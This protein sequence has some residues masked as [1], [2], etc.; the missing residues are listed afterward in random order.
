MVDSV[1]VDLDAKTRIAVNRVREGLMTITLDDGKSEERPKIEL[2]GLKGGP[3]T[4]N[5]GCGKS[6]T[7]DPDTSTHLRDWAELL[8]DAGNKQTTK[9]TRGYV[10]QDLVNAT[11][12]AA[13][14]VCAAER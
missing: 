1:K 5:T 14:T 2:S 8:L 7:L 11:R 3:L 13:T 10:A 9:T 12:K 4:L 6:I